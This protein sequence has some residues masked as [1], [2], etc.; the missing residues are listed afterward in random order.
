MLVVHPGPQFSVHDV[1]M[2]WQEALIDMGIKTLEYNLQDRIAFYDSAYVFTGG[3]DG[4]GNARFRKALP[5]RDQVVSMS[6]NGILSTCFSFWPDV[7]LIVSAFFVGTHEMDIM[8]SRGIKVVLLHTESPYEE[9]AQVKRSTH[10]D[11]ALLNDPLRLADYDAAGVP[12]IYMPHAYRPGLHY[13]GPGSDEL[14]TDFAFIGTGY[15]SRVRF[16]EA[17]IAAGAFEGI[18]V[19]LGGNWQGEA[20]QTPVINYLSHELNECVDNALTTRV[21]RSAKMGLNLY[22]HEVTDSGYSPVAAG[23]R[24]IEMAACG[25]PFLREP[26]PESDE[27]F[28]MLPAFAGPEDAAEQLKWWLAH[29]DERHEAALKARAAVRH[30]TFT[31]NAQVLL[32]ALDAL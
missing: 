24:E 14:A 2:G 19:T 1:Y 7:V 4:N 17:M 29:E 12:A 16:F 30:R 28:P 15:P 31:A 21:Y 13:P 11:L 5:N 23:P 27:L 32:K 8:R 10:A 25:L 20:E 9:P 26:G 18:D 3:F 22:R 6:C